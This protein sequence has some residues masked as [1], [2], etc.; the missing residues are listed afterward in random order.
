MFSGTLCD[1]TS[2]TQI[3]GK[4]NSRRIAAGR[5][6]RIRCREHQCLPNAGTA[7]VPPM[8]RR[9]GSPPP[10]GACL[11]LRRS[12]GARLAEIQGQRVVGDLLRGGSP[13]RSGD[14]HGLPESSRQ[15]DSE[16]FHWDCVMLFLDF[17]TSVG[18]G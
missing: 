9:L 11:N 7:R 3:V 17:C 13:L 4:Q 14:L 6:Q 18:H 2:K 16:L 15:H 12:R 10:G 1:V 8:P 5:R